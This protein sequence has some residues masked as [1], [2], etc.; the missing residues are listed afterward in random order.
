MKHASR[1]L[2]IPGYAVPVIAGAVVL[3]VCA[4]FFGYMGRPSLQ[5]VMNPD[6]E[7]DAP[8]MVQP[9]EPEAPSQDQPIAPASQPVLQKPAESDNAS[10]A[11]A[12]SPFTIRFAATERCWMRFTV[13]GK[14]VFE[15]TL[16]KGDTYSVNAV[17]DIKVRIGNPGGVTAFYNNNHVTVSGNRGRP[18][19]M[20]FPLV[21]THTASLVTLKTGK[22]TARQKIIVVQGPTGVGKTDVWACPCPGDFR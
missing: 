3:L 16:K 4:L 9:R 12:P 19:E 5:T 22:D 8:I 6:N 18:V 1:P 11:A 20:S 2:L 14:H 21:G 17:S 10:A 7:A 13:D 15:V